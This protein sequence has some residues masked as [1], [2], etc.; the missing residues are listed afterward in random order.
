MLSLNKLTLELLICAIQDVAIALLF[1]TISQVFSRN[2][3]FAPLWQRHGSQSGFL[4]L[5]KLGFTPSRI[6]MAVMLS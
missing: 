5:S 1:T 2:L 4:I 3:Y 6:A